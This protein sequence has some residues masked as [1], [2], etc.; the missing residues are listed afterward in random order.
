MSDTF[1]VPSGEGRSHGAEG[2]RFAEVSDV[3]QNINEGLCGE[4]TIQNEVCKYLLH[5]QFRVMLISIFVWK[6][7]K[8]TTQY[9]NQRNMSFLIS[10]VI[11]WIWYEQG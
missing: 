2:K 5:L 11:S 6:H 4:V 3:T 7:C 8:K 1:K 10:Y 9:A